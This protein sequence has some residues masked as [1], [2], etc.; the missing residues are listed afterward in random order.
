MTMADENKDKKTKDSGSF[1]KG[2]VF[3]KGEI[4][5]R[6][7]NTYQGFLK[8][9]LRHGYGKME[10]ET[11]VFNG[12]LLEMGMYY[13]EWKRDKRNG[14]GTMDGNGSKFV[15]IWKNDKM[16]EGKY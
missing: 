1:L 12:D 13:G 10:F 15:G 3:G 7:G 8:G 5:Y 2:K 9:S 6:N 4:K 14:K 16:H 11:P